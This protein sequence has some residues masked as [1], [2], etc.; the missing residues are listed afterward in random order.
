MKKKTQINEALNT[1]P[2]HNENMDGVKGSNLK[3]AGRTEIIPADTL[4]K[5]ENTF[6]DDTN[7]GGDNKS[8]IGRKVEITGIFTIF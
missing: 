2:N 6:M 1:I 5:H 3:P 4:K 8:I 7:N